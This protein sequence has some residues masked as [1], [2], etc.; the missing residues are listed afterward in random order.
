[1]GS[2]QDSGDVCNLVLCLASGSLAWCVDLIPR[3]FLSLS[4]FVVK[5][6]QYLACYSLFNFVMSVA[7]GYLVVT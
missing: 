3:I 1:M 5:G 6:K 2:I 4:A 7:C